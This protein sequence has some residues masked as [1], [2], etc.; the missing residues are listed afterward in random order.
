[1]NDDER[2]QLNSEILHWKQQTELL[3]E[4]MEI[5]MKENEMLRNSVIM[6]Q[7]SVKKLCFL[8]HEI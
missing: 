6:N 4:K 2:H 8:R 5:L 7:S 1:M 3:L